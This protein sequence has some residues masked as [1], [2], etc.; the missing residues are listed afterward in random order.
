MDESKADF[1]PAINSGIEDRAHHCPT[2]MKILILAITSI[3]VFQLQTIRAA[4]PEEEARFVAAAKLAF[5]KHDTDALVALTCWDQVPN[6]L[7]ADGQQQ[8]AGIINYAKT[9]AGP[10]VTDIKLLDPDK[11]GTQWREVD[12]GTSG[13]C[14]QVI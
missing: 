13:H 1:Q 6:K 7:K 3:L 12:S 4:S 11:S 5:E 10:P 14:R 8:Y 9:I 2:L